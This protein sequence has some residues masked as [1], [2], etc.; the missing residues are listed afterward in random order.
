MHLRIAACVIC[1]KTVVA[2]RAKH[3]NF[4]SRSA[5]CSGKDLKSMVNQNCLAIQYYI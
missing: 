1:A 5:K 4:S 2:K 3:I